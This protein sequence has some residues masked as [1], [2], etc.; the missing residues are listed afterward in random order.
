MYRFAEK[1]N[2]LARKDGSG[3]GV[4]EYIAPHTHRPSGSRGG[5][6]YRRGYRV[7]LIAQ[8][9]LNI[10]NESRATQAG[11]TERFGNH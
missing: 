7:Q 3:K 9:N 2:G 6:A 5:L 10:M 8:P 11:E 1:K 4:M